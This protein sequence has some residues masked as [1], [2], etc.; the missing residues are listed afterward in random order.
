MCHFHYFLGY[1]L[2]LLVSTFGHSL[3]LGA[4]LCHPLAGIRGAL[5]Q[6]TSRKYS[7]TLSDT[8]PASK[9]PSVKIHAPLSAG[10][11]TFCGLLVLESG[12]LFTL[13]VRWSDW[14]CRWACLFH[15]MGFLGI[16][17]G[18]FCRAVEEETLPFLFRGR[19]VL[20][21]EIGK[22][23]AENGVSKQ[24]RKIWK[25]ESTL[26]RNSASCTDGP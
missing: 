4:I 16:L 1:K 10:D 19:W 2:F 11:V 15:V 22:S 13:L 7:L 6:R 3:T 18:C 8:K 17:R 20:S 9:S 12:L 5:E 21:R 23:A 25:Q 14:S 24:R 26:H